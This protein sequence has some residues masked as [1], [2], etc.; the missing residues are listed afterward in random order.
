MGETKKKDSFTFHNVSIKTDDFQ[1]RFTHG[2]TFTFHNVSIKT[3]P[4]SSEQFQ[5]LHWPLFI[6]HLHHLLFAFLFFF[7]CIIGQSSILFSSCDPSVLMMWPVRKHSPSSN[8]SASTSQNG[9]AVQAPARPP[10]L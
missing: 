9:Q 6:K 4:Y 5:N 8:F 3:T 7:L 10:R 2:R 1:H